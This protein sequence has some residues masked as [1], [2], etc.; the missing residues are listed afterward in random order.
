MVYLSRN[1]KLDSS[2]NVRQSRFYRILNYITLA[3]SLQYYSQQHFFLV[4]CSDENRQKHVDTRCVL[5][6]CQIRTPK[7]HIGRTIGYQIHYR[8]DTK[9]PCKRQL[10]M[11]T[12]QSCSWIFGNFFC[13][14]SCKL[15]SAIFILILSP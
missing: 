10:F 4:F 8:A 9:T 7:D 3:T 6:A 12:N 1:I 5:N 14:I 2:S 15:D 13:M 11:Y